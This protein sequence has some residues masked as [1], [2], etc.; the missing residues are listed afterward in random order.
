MRRVLCLFYYFPPTGGAGALRCLAYARGLLE[1]GWRADVVAP[2]GPVYHTPGEDLLS[3]VP[4]DVRVHRTRNFEVRRLFAPL[5]AL[6]IPL[7]TVARLAR[8]VCLPDYQAGWIPFA[9]AEADRLLRGERF[10]AIL[11]SGA[12]WSAHLA[13]GRLARG[14]KLPWV[15]TFA[16]EWSTATEVPMASAFHRHLHRRWERRVL[17]SSLPAAATRGVA[18]A[19][20]RAHPGL[21]L[22]VEIVGN[23]YEEADFA[24]RSGRRPDRFTLLFAGSVYAQKAPWTLL[25]AL[26]LLLRKRPS[27]RDAIRLRVLGHPDPD[28]SARV[29]A[30]GLADLV[31]AEGARPHAEAVQAMLDAH[32]L[33]AEIAPHPGAAAVRPVKLLEYLR[34]GNPILGVFPP[35]EA[36]DLLARFPDCA[37][38]APGDAGAAAGALAAWLTRWREGVW[39]GPGPGPDPAPRPRDRLAEGPVV[40]GAAHLRAPNRRPGLHRLSVERDVRGPAHGAA[41]ARPLWLWAPHARD[42]EGV[43]RQ[44]PRREPAAARGPA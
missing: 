16:D 23:G 13:A 14:H 34:A 24:G 15:A 31:M 42:G 3:C 28:F 19:L 25:E 39:P 11:S 21:D 17:A 18:E 37:P 40:P 9:C 12:P 29:R 10:D 22:E 6:G 8:A 30:L 2:S 20:R 36:A 41:H 38:V 27:E 26:A 35:G 44:D 4:P 1:H 43:L 5:R 32:V 33:V 7:E